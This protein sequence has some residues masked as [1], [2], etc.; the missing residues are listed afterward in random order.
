MHVAIKEHRKKGRKVSRAWI[1]IKAKKLQHERDKIDGATLSS[2]FKAS[3]GWFC[4]FFGARKSSSASQN[5][6]RRK[7]WMTTWN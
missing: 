6:E 5:Q 4:A 3:D 2:R 1:C 7:L